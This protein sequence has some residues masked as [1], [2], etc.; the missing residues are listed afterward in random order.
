MKTLLFHIHTEKSPDAAIKIPEL[1][2]FILKNKISYFCITDHH[3]IEGCN[4]MEKLL[5]KYKR[6]TKL[7]KGIEITTEYGDIIPC[8]IKKEIKTRK[9]LEVVEETRKQKGLLI[10]PHPFAA[11]RKINFLIKYADGIEVHNGNALNSQNKKAK[12]L[13]GKNP[14]L[15]TISAADA[16]CMN[17]LGN[18]L[19]EIKLGKRLKIIPIL[20]R[21]GGYFKLN[22][23]HSAIKIL[24]LAKKLL[25]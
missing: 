13:S 8:F 18:G 14:K 25:K 16:H 2:N 5:K 20:C 11:H 12:M 21:E 24:K 10:I 19:N 6:K 17:E 3:T 22:I 4:E 9:F 7:I 15:L 23:K 1:L